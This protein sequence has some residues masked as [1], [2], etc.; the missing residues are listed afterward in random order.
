MGSLDG[1]SDNHCE[2]QCCNK[3]FQVIMPTRK[4]RATDLANELSSIIQRPIGQ[5]TLSH[6]Q[7]ISV[8][9][10]LGKRAPLENDSR[11]P[12]AWSFQLLISIR[13]A[14]SHYW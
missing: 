2:I 7:L 3:L 9:R 5:L 6:C 13:R 12:Y 10:E 11:L 4:S 1:D 14:P 8:V